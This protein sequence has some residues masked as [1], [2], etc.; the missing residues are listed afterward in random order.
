[1]A[2]VQKK[3]SKWDSKHER[4]V[5]YFSHIPHGFYEK[6]M[7]GFLTQFGTVTN[8]RVGRSSRTG[9]AKGYAFVEFLYMDVAKIVAETMN[10]Y[11]MFE[12]LVKCQLVPTEKV[13]R[14]MFKQRVN[15]A[16]PPLLISR[17]KAKKIMNSKRTEKQT[18]RRLQRQTKNLTNVQAK[19][20][21]LGI[22]LV[23]PAASDVK[24]PTNS[25]VG[26]KNKAEMKK[27]S[28][29]PV[30]EVDESD[31]DIS[32]KTPPA[33][34]KIKSRSNSTANSAANSAANTP[35]NST[36]NAKLNKAIAEKL[37]A[38][39]LKEKKSNKKSPSNKRP[40]MNKKIK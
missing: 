28:N 11:L 5:V 38:K 32:L 10:N 26:K 33:V 21:E 1:M 20:R 30:M 15:I 2:E 13:T 36:K 25:K 17:F 24:T 4:G 39:M 27:A 8:L 29:T 16:R 6:E 35:K 14:A 7:R 40:L 19:L 22:N 23:L 3:K 18:E 12:K 31:L 9:R 34:K 37:T